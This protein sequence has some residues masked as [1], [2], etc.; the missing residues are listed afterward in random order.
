MFVESR[1]FTMVTEKIN[2]EAIVDEMLSSGFREFKPNGLH[3]PSAIKGFQ[4]KYKDEKGIKY[5]ITC[6]EYD[7]NGFPDHGRPYHKSW[8]FDGQFTLV[9]GKTFNF[10]TVGWFFFPTEWGHK[11]C[12]LKD[13]ESFFEEMWQ[14]MNCV[15]YEL[16]EPR[17]WVD[18]S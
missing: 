5:Y 2:Y 7:W 6:H 11:I 14:C 15:H 18:L 8:M 12:T 17:N 13:V 1:N 9:D 10:E 16:N 3:K 4:K